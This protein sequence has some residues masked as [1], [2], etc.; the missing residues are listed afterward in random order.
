MNFLYVIRIVCV[1]ACND[2]N[3]NGV[4]LSLLPISR[5][6]VN[7]GEIRHYHV[8]YSHCWALFSFFVF[9]P[10]NVLDS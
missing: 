5:G 8:N 9:I 6:L 2:E 4:L 3:D 7:Y 10:D 1:T